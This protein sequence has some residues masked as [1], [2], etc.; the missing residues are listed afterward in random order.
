MT[1]SLIWAM[2]RNRVIGKA[3][4]LP[5]DLPDELAHFRATTLG[6]P[7]IMGRRT[8]LSANGPLAG[9]PNIVLSRRGFA[10]AGAATASSLD[11]ALALAARRPA[12]ECFVIGGVEPF[13]QALPRAHRLYATTIDA[14]LEGD[15]FFPPFDLAAWRIVSRERHPADARHR[16]AY[17]I[18]VYERT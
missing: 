16:H 1:L 6:K 11:E 9:R 8:F 7:V 15:V 12:D 2:T 14:H 4:R 13:S 10:T 18:E 17:E 5:W 3:G